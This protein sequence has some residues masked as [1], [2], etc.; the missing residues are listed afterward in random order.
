LWSR[1][2]P[3]DRRLIAKVL[4]GQTSAYAELVHRYQGRL[5][6]AVV[7]ILD[8]A[9]DAADV[10]Q[11]TFVSAYQ[12]LG[13]FKGD[14]EF[15]TWL[16]RIAFNTAISAKRKRKPTVSLDGHRDQDN[17]N[18]A[19]LDPVDR[20]RDQFPGANLE[21]TDD[22]R[23]LADAIRRLSEEHR[24]VLVLKDLEGFRYDEIAGMIG[25]PVGTVRSRLNRARLELRSILNPTATGPLDFGSTEGELR[26]VKR[27]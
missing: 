3:E 16:Y 14:A 11:D 27:T 4:A 10:V 26:T 5:F 21:R 9:E 18:P 12:S 15:F 8:N 13:T 20:G 7:R 19:G 1:V 17:G 23:M 2:N 22:E 24:A 6:G 25:V